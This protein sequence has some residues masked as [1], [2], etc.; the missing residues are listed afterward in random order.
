VKPPGTSTIRASLAATYIIFYVSRRRSR[1]EG[2]R[3]LE[4]ATPTVRGLE[5]AIEE[6]L[7]SD[8]IG[9]AKE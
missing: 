9:A 1:A 4:A 5:D 8:Q 3:R 2:E 6:D 7:A